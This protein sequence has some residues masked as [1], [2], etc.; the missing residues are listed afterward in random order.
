[1]VNYKGPSYDN[2]LAVVREQSSHLQGD[3]MTPNIALEAI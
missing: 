1:M 3:T 2:A